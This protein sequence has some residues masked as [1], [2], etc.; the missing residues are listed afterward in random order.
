M[1]RTVR[2]IGSD[3]L[4]RRF[5]LNLLIAFA[6]AVV[7]G[8]AFGGLVK[9]HL[10]HPVPVATAFV[11]GGFVILWVERRHRRLFGERFVQRQRDRRLRSLAMGDL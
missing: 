7:L 5:A 6:P 3:P 4:A 11:V 8:L 1:G 2:G 10:F 9:A